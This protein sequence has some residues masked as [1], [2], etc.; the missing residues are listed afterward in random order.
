MIKNRNYSI[1]DVRSFGKES[2]L[3]F[4]AWQQ[5]WEQLA[6]LSRALAEAC[7]GRSVTAAPRSSARVAGLSGWKLC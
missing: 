6:V 5:T 1:L 7:D 3:A 4:W 2:W